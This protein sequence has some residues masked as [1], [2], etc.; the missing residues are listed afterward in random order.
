MRN[1]NNQT[2]KNLSLQVNPRIICNLLICRR[3]VLQREAGRQVGGRRRGGR[4]QGALHQGLRGLRRLHRVR[5]QCGR[6][7]RDGRLLQRVRQVRGHNGETET[8]PCKFLHSHFSDFFILT[9]QTSSL[10]YFRF[11]RKQLLPS[12]MPRFLGLARYF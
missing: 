8:P 9:F 7:Q 11:A 2:E 6:H 3:G 1:K 4:R 5:Q 12:L 10:L